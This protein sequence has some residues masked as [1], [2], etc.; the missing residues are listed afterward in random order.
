MS[1]SWKFPLILLSSSQALSQSISVF[2]MTLSSLAGAHLSPDPALATL[3]VAAVI[4]GTLAGLFPLARWMAHN[5]RRSGFRLGVFI[6]ALGALLAVGGLAIASPWV[7][8]AGHFLMGIQQGGFQY[9]RFTAS[10]IVP[11]QHRSR[12]I[13]L[14]LAGGIVAAFLGPWLAHFSR[15]IGVDIPYGLAYGPLV[16]LYGILILNFVFMPVLEESSPL[17]KQ[18]MELRKP[19]SLLRIIRQPAYLQALLGSIVGYALMILLMT[20]TPLA[21][22]HGGHSSQDISWV[23]Q[24]HVL[25]MFVPSFFTGSLIKRLGHRSIL[26]L[27]ILAI[28]IDVL[29]AIFLKGLW[30]YWVSLVLLGIGWNFLYIASTSRLTGTYRPEEKEK[31]QAAHDIVVFTVNT[32]ATYSA[33][34]LLKSLGWITIHLW[35]LPLLMVTA[36][37]I[38][39]PH[40]KKEGNQK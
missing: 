27:G 21:M 12:G 9:L 11:E 29:A 14:V 2:I 30:S 38:L 15:S 5:G 6:G 7:F 39:I 24:W 32:L 22:D 26:A 36:V 25:G 3:P 18:T 13:S 40:I 37:L 19:R 35:V 31:T 8:A 16:G 23:I 10:E 17:L 20:A 28:L 34:I 33:A 4:L 1:R